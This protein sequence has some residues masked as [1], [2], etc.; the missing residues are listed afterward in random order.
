MPPP[1]AEG[2]PDGWRA[3]VEER[4]GMAFAGVRARVLGAAVAARAAAAG[5]GTADAYVRHLAGA[6]GDA[7]WHRLLA[8]LL[9][10]DTRFFR[11]PPALAALTGMALPELR[12]RPGGR[13]RVAV[14]SAGC[15]TGQEAYSVAIACLADPGHAGQ[16]VEV[17][18]TDVCRSALARAAVGA[19]RAHELVGVPPDLKGR[20][21]E[22]QGGRPGAGFRVAPGVRAAVRFER[23]DLL[24]GDVP[25][26]RDVVF[27]QNVLIYYR[28]DRRA[29]ILGRLT[30][31][32]APGGYLFLGA[33][34]AV[35]VP[36]PGLDLIR[37]DDA[38]VYRRTC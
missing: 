10:R 9:N 1:T 20:F 38:W 23:G 21:F 15:S 22:P 36:T 33:A 28:P 30:R 13:D 16:G 11:D 6:A 27:C 31:A 8:L 7:E 32:L 2:A 26:A 5:C 34:E 14:W 37:L 25:A 35:G 12:R 19:Y 4:S 17:L 24:G 3:Y 29:E 18:G